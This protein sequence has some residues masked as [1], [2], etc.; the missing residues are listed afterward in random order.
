[1]ADLDE[2]AQLHADVRGQDLWGD[3][4]GLSPVYRNAQL[5]RFCGALPPGALHPPCDISSFTIGY[6]IKNS[7]QVIITPWHEDIFRDLRSS[8]E[9]GVARALQM[10]L[11][12]LANKMQTMCR[13]DQKN[14]DGGGNKGCQQGTRKTSQS[15]S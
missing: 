1:M 9:W 2:L 12:Y 4:D 14:G 7:S 13:A 15:T 11:C 5:Q 8:L 3:T 10:G 6:C